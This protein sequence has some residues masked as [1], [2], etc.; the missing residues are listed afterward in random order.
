M[1]CA[2]DRYQDMSLSQ[3]LAN[4]PAQLVKAHLN[5]SDATVAKLTKEKE[6]VV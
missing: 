3:W 4:T 6:Y 2:A 1:H 5:I